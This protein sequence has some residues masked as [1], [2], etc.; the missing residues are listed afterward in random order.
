MRTMITQTKP[1][2]LYEK[3]S[4]GFQFAET[5]INQFAINSCSKNT[6]VGTESQ[7][8]G[9]WMQQ[10]EGGVNVSVGEGDGGGGSRW[11]EAEAGGEAGWARQRVEGRWWRGQHEE[12]TNEAGRG[13]NGR[14]SRVGR[15]RQHEKVVKGA[16]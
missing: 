6:S 7:G 1:E 11:V 15:M 16:T 2:I 14:E 5:K 12:G 3:H 8:C 9:R 10:W 13:G 4:Q